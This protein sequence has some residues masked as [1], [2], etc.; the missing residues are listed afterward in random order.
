MR[1]CTGPGGF[2]Q[3]NVLFVHL[4]ATSYR[5]I[6][7]LQITLLEF[8]NLIIEQVVNRTFFR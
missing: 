3:Q 4:H 1:S 2:L 5:L 7:P 6:L 8:G